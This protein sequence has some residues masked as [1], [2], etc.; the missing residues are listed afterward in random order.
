MRI[1]YIYKLTFLPSKS[2][3]IGSSTEKNANP[4]LF[5]TKYFTSSKPIKDLIDQY[6]I[7]DEYWSYVILKTFSNEIDRRIVFK[8]EQLLIKELYDSDENT[9]NKSYIISPDPM[10][11]FGSTETKSDIMKLRL[12]NSIKGR[13]L[14][15]MKMP[16]KLDIFKFKNKK[17][18]DE[19]E[20]TCHAFGIYSGLTP[21]EIYN[22]TSRRIRYSKSWGVY[23]ESEQKYSYEIPRVLPNIE[24]KKCHHCNKD[25]SPGNFERWHGEKCS[26][27]IK[28]I[29]RF[30][31]SKT[32]IIFTGTVEEFSRFASLEIRDINAMLNRK[33]SRKFIKNWGVFLPEYNKYSHEIPPASFIHPQTT[34]I[35]CNKIFNNSTFSVYHGDRCKMR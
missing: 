15:H 12:S 25:V 35:H 14:P 28:E 32:D 33:S 19:F 31:N 34:C 6:G 24:N 16:K 9:L 1:Q 26:V 8:E 27:K 17:T 18:L 22:I 2:H 21:Q 29:Y 11:F 5:W 4:N 30:S 7:S 10:K 13:V 20:G 3:Y 23:I